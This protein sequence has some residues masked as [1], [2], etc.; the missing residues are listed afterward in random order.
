MTV[1]TFLHIWIAI[2]SFQSLYYLVRSITGILGINRN[3]YP[4]F[5]EYLSVSLVYFS[6][7]SGFLELAYGFRVVQVKVLD[8]WDPCPVGLSVTGV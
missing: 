1:L 6:C 7:A 2:C 5:V 3:C 8:W 4:H